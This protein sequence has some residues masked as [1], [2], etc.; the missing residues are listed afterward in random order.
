MEFDRSEVTGTVNYYPYTFN[1]ITQ[2]RRILFEGGVPL[3]EI[4]YNLYDFCLIYL[5]KT[6]KNVD[7]YLTGIVKQTNTSRT[8]VPKIIVKLKGQSSK[9]KRIHTLKEKLPILIDLFRD[10]F[11]R[12]ITEDG[13]TKTTYRTDI[14]ITQLKT[15]KAFFMKEIETKLLSLIK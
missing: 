9:L 5:N 3:H 12:Y 13:A 14:T 11:N 2:E 6:S 10:I 1:N 8:C 4:V 7:T 15:A